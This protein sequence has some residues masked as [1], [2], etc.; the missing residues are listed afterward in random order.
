[1][2]IAALVYALLLILDSSILFV[3]LSGIW[4][5]FN[6]PGVMSVNYPMTWNL[7]LRRYNGY[8]NESTM[9]NVSR[10]GA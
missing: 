7:S 5:Y 2:E 4:A 1:M 9:P 6:I 8:R 10:D 3:L